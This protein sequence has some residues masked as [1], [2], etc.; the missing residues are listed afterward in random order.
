MLE[1]VLDVFF[2]GSLIKF[3]GIFP[4]F[5]PASRKIEHHPVIERHL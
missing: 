4:K 2:F 1:T 3:D 5:W